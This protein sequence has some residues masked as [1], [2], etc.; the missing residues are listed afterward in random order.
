MLENACCYRQLLIYSKPS[1]SYRFSL[2]LY[3]LYV[4][5]CFS[6]KKRSLYRAQVNSVLSVGVHIN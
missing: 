3:K 4:T 1:V 2:T 5:A 6:D